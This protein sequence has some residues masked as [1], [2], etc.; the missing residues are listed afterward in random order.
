MMVVLL[1]VEERPGCSPRILK[2]RGSLSSQIIV[3]EKEICHFLYMS[4]CQTHVSELLY[5]FHTEIWSY[6]FEKCPHQ[7]FL[8]FSVWHQWLYDTVLHLSAL[9]TQI[10]FF[11]S[12][13]GL[14]LHILQNLESIQVY[15][16][17]ISERN[18]SPAIPQAQLIGFTAVIFLRVLHPCI[19]LPPFKFQLE[20]EIMDIN[21]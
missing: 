21:T 15:V 13:P 4:L 17:S 12:S 8:Q 16:P 5:I 11:L 14:K 19:L 9:K 10:P 6:I 7:L 18:A 1:A 2:L 3:K 20:P